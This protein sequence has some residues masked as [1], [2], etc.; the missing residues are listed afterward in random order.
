MQ[1]GAKTRLRRRARANQRRQNINHFS[2]A[3]THILMPLRRT[4]LRMLQFCCRCLETP[5]N[6]PAA[7]PR[8]DPRHFRPLPT[9]SRSLSRTFTND[10]PVLLRHPSC[11]RSAAG[12]V[13]AQ[14]LIAVKLLPAGMSFFVGK[15]VRMPWPTRRNALSRV[16]ALRSQSEQTRPSTQRSKL[17]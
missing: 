13:E 10:L 7:P 17:T 2:R 14:N 6:R 3:R 9:A 1:G 5:C 16:P 8:P 4:P 12:T 11:R 15:H